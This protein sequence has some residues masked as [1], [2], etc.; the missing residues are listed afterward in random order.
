MRHTAQFATDMQLYEAA[1]Y[2]VLYTNLR[3]STGYGQP[4][5][6]ID[7]YPDGDTPT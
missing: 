1:G 2:A 6:A 7:S 4:A 5:D 3:G